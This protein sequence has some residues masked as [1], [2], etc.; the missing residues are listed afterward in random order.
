MNFRFL[1]AYAAYSIAFGA[2]WGAPKNDFNT[3]ST[4]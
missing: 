3:E 2:D 1:L 4:Q